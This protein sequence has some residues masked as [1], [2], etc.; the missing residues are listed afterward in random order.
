MSK[1]EQG[2]GRNGFGHFFRVHFFS[3]FASKVKSRSI[4]RPRYSSPPK[5]KLFPGDSAAQIPNPPSGAKTVQQEMC[6]PPP[7]PSL[8]ITG[9]I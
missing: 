2:C 1:I 9:F 3:V 4:S 6:Y 8:P 5:F 7:Q